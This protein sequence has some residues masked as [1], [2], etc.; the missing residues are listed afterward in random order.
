MNIP[1]SVRV[2]SLTYTLTADPEMEEYGT[3]NAYR[4][5]IRYNPEQDFRQ[6]RD[7]VWHE[8]LHACEAFMGIHKVSEADLTRLATASLNVLRDN[9]ALVEFLTEADPRD[10]RK[11]NRSMTRG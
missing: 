1:D 3:C 4:L 5:S 8:T 2:L 7:T 9:P 11:R 10:K 6:L